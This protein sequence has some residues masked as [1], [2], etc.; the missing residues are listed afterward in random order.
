MIAFIK[1]NLAAAKPISVVVEAAGVGYQVLIAANV[2]PALPAIGTMITLHTSFI[3]R[4]NSHI[5]YGFLSV[6][7]KDFFEELMG[8]SGI[9]PKLALSLIG[10]LPI[11]DLC[12]AINEA[13]IALISKVPGIGKRTSERLILE[14]RG[15]LTHLASY[16]AIDLSSTSL[17]SPQAQKIHDAMSALINLGYNQI[18]AQ[19][20]IKKTINDLPEEIDLAKLITHA[21]NHV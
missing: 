10:H 6:G 3:V 19:N 2:F 5:L 4:E 11:Q 1:G 17:S 13:N 20:A 12:R 21:L 15:K 9:G 18:T 14:M 7:E 8:V 16:A